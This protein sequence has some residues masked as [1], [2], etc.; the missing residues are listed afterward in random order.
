MIRK[1]YLGVTVAHHLS[2]NPTSILA[3]SIPA[4]FPFQISHADELDELFYDELYELG[5]SLS[6]AEESGELSWWILKPAMADKGQGIRL[7]SSSES[8]QEILESFEDDSDDDEDAGVKEEDQGVG[9]STKVSLSTM[10]DWVIQVR[11]RKSLQ[12]V[13]ALKQAGKERST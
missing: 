4:T 9:P 5:Q 2:K 11:A 13:S 12:Y 6:R 7:F 8:L 3:K 10:R 1:S